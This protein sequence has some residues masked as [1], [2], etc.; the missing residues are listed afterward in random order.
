MLFFK[1]KDGLRLNYE[2]C[3]NG[4]QKVILVMGLGSSKQGWDDQWTHFS[5]EQQQNRFTVCRFD[6]RGMGWSDCNIFFQ[7]Y[8]TKLLADDVLTLLH[9]LAWTERVNLV[10]ISLGGMVSLVN[11]VYVVSICL[12]IRLCQ[13]TLDS[14]VCKV[15]C[16]DNIFHTTMTARVFLTLLTTISQVNE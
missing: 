9:H 4:P 7:R 6:N 12:K 3:G 2:V 16:C 1:T 14:C 10:G 5:E 13:M 15:G 8:T 11:S